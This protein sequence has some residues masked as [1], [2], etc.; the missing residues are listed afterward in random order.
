MAATRLRQ[1]AVYISEPSA[2]DFRWVL[3]EKLQDAEWSDFQHAEAGTSSYQQAM[4]D[5]LTA[6]QALEFDL[7]EGPRAPVQKPQR[8][9]QRAKRSKDQVGGDETQ[10]RDETST[11]HSQRSAFGFGLAK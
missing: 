7:D 3:A 6:L 9:R 5:G 8:A 10:L 11:R 2:G 4:A 1:I